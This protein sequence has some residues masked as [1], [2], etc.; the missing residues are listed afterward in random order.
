MVQ[1]YFCQKVQEDFGENSQNASNISGLLTLKR[2]LA[3]CE[4]GMSMVGDALKHS[5]VVRSNSK[6]KSGSS[7]IG[8]FRKWI[9][10]DFYQKIPENVSENPQKTPKNKRTV[11]FEP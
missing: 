1:K 9:K 7:S 10:K 3:D 11:D 6:T 8:F 5:I 2:D 4:C